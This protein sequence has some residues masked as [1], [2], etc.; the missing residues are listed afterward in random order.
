MASEFNPDNCPRGIGNEKSIDNLKET[1]NLMI[2]HLNEKI[3]D[4][5]E[6]LT[7]QMDTGFENVNS[8]LDNLED[9]FNKLEAGLDEKIEDRINRSHNKFSSKIVSWIFGGLGSAVI[10]ALVTNRVLSHF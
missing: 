8:K 1:F 2:Q 10:I 5:K 6:S 7:S 9:R 4:M 3:D